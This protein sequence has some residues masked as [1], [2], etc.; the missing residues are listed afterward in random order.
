MAEM[1]RRWFAK[2]NYMGSSP[3]IH[4]IKGKDM[5]SK[6]KKRIELLEGVY[7]VISHKDIYDTIDYK[8]KSE[9]SIKQFMYQPLLQSFKKRM[10]SNGIKEDKAH[11]LAEQ[12][13]TWE[14]NKKT[15]LHNMV[16][17]STQHRPDMEFKIDGINVAI[18]IKK[19]KCG[20]DLRQGIGQCIVY[21]T[22]YDFV[23]FLFVDTSDDKKVF[24]SVTSRKEV[25]VIKGLWKNYNTMFGII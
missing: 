23:I 19:G 25:D 2:P 5:L 21:S 22:K 11:K 20:V 10:M 3:F 14:A 18:E 17:F 9:E 6:T 16:L 24:N 1:D 4:S 12:S 8:R 15:T 7:D 13:L